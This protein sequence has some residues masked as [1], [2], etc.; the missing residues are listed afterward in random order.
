MKHY[1]AAKPIGLAGPCNE[2]AHTCGNAHLYKRC[3]LR[4]NHYII[5]LNPGSGRTT[6]LEYMTD[7]YRKAGVLSFASGPDDYIEVT[8]D[9][10]LQQLEQAFA[11]IDAAAV[12]TNEYCNVIGMDISGIAA[13]L[14][15]TQLPEFLKHCKRVCAHAC[16]VFFVYAIPSRNEEKLLEKLCETVSSIKRLETEPYCKEDICALIIKKVGERGIEIKHEDAFW[17]ALEDMVSEFDMT[18]VQDAIAAADGLIH[19]ADFSEFT[20]A[21]DESSLKS[22]L[23]DWHKKTE[24]SG[25]K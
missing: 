8:F 3:G 6:L 1:D 15:E 24:R 13:H 20:P 5:P 10:S 25:V 4:P 17:A 18:G 14:G 19:F 21:V 23:A 7:Q 9:G 2:I 22:M 12:Y 11:A 16:V